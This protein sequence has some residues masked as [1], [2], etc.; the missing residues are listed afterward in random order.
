MPI[1][2]GVLCRCYLKSSLNSKLNSCINMQTLLI[3]TSIYVYI[4]IIFI[5]MYII[6]IY[7]HIYIYIYIHIHTYIYIYIIY[8]IYNI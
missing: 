6:Y 2:F 4:Y 3:K 5:N 7:I 1:A 8:N